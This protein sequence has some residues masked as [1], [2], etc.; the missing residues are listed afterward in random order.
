MQTRYWL[1][2]FYLI[3]F[4][5]LTPTR[6][7]YAAGDT[8]TALSNLS[9][10]A[11][12]VLAPILATFGLWVVHRV[13]KLLESKLSFDLP[14]Q[15]EAKIDEWIEHGIHWAEEKSRQ[16]VIAKTDKLSGPEKLETAADFVLGFVNARGWD[17]W[18]RDQIKSK[19]ESKL[20]IHRAN[21]S[22][23]T[24]DKGDTTE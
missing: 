2:F 23:P 12:E 21:S 6:I 20:G 4:L 17:A 15:Q 24:L 3:V 1:R 16:K 7:A 8:S 5:C 18:T 19:I 14:S 11:F 10:M 9:Q 22:K 13:I